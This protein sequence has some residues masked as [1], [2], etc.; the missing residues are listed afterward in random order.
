VAA[1]SILIY[2]PLGVD[3]TYSLDGMTYAPSTTF[4]DLVAGTYTLTVKNTAGCVSPGT[5]FTVDPQPETPAAPTLAITQPNCEVSTGTITITAPLGS[6]LQYSIN[7]EVFQTEPSFTGLTAG[8]YEV[9]VENAFGCA[10]STTA[11]IVAQPGAPSQPVAIVTQPDCDTPLGSIVISAPMGD[12][13]AYSIDGVTFTGTLSYTDLPAGTYTVTAVNGAGC[14]SAPLM[15]T[16]LP[17]PEV[18][19]APVLEVTQPDCLVLTGTIEVS[20]PLGMYY[21]SVDGS[22]YTTSVLFTDLAPGA[23]SVTV[24]AGLEGCVSQATA[25]LINLPPPPIQPGPTVQVTNP[26]C[27]QTTG[28]ISITEP[29]ASDYTYSIDGT[30]YTSTNLFEELTPGTY[31]VSFKTAEGCVSVPVTATVNEPPVIPTP[32]LTLTQPTCAVPT[33][34]IEVTSPLGDEYMYVLQ[35]SSTSSTWSSTT[36]FSELPAGTYTLTVDFNEICQSESVVVTLYPPVDPVAD[37]GPDKQLGCSVTEVVLDGFSETEGVIYAWE[38][39][40]IVSGGDTATP[41]VNAGGTYTLTVTHVMS[42]CSAT[43]V[44]EVTAGGV[45][46]VLVLKDGYCIYLTQ[47]G[48]WTLNA[49]DIAQITAGSVSGSGNW[50][51]LSFTFSRRSFECRDAYPPY[52]K[53]TV[54]ATDAGGCTVSG[55]FNLMVL[56][57]IAPVAKCRNFTVELDAFG[58]VL[59]VPG[60]INDGGDRESAPEWA[61]YYKD[62]EGGS[63]DNCGIAEMFLSK[64]IFTRDDVGPNQVVLTVID[65]SGNIAECEATVTVVDPYDEEAG[66]PGEGDNEDGEDPD[67][68][69]PNSAPTLADVKDIDIMNQSLQLDVQLTGISAGTETNQKVKVTAVTD[70]PSVVTGIAVIYT[71][72]STGQLLVTVAPGM[73]GEAWITVTVKDDGGTANGGVDLIQKKFKVKVTYSGEEVTIGITDPD[74]EDVVTKTIDLAASM[75]FRLYPNPTQGKV[76]IE[77]MGSDI[78]NTEVS[79]FTLQG[80][81]VFRKQFRAGEKITLDLSPYV[82]GIYMVRTGVEGASF[83]R[84]VILEK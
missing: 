8:I 40:G 31:Q 51:D 20:S 83:L 50:S 67:V 24:M 41:T 30:T 56:D 1:G 44:V 34:T 76:N 68:V 11:T 14:H 37:A 27:S 42:Q 53:V 22:T 12:E 17:Q 49:Y 38:G 63:Y 81:E 28:S 18:P 5:V 70:N 74:G 6:G 13:L 69:L 73:S 32:V 23:Y 79:V 19:E 36:V 47:D 35:T 72:G 39:P 26:D 60:F 57:T 84:K 66:V 16:I 59:V 33:G 55:T 75:G 61:K 29:S 65:P 64:S 10:S 48:K 82:S 43:D 45:P 7:G 80:A 21:Y 78:R 3:L 77:L 52:A 25:T 62:L 2:S 4:T 46:P 15:V 9:I 58:Q 71:Q 54:T